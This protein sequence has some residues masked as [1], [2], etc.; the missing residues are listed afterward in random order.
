MNSVFDLRKKS[1]PITVDLTEKRGGTKQGL[2]KTIIG[3][4][5][6]MQKNSSVMKKAI[7]EIEKSREEARKGNID[8]IKLQKDLLDCRTDVI[9]KIERTVGK[10]LKSY[11]DAV[12]E[13]LKEQSASIDKIDSTLYN[14]L[15]FRDKYYIRRSKNQVAQPLSFSKI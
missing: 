5:A 4:M 6:Q 12:N 10:Q 15:Q 1:T 14:T 13:N 3:L 7:T 2:A 8:V 11:S 9:S